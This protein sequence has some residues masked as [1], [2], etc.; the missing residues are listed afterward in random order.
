MDRVILHCDCNG[1][2]ASVECA[3]RPELKSV[4]MIVGGDQQARHGIVLAKNELAKKY[5]I[6]TAETVWQA[7]KKCPHLVIVPPHHDRY[8]YY[9]RMINRVY[10]EYTDL[11]EPFG[12]DESWLDVTGSLRLFGSG[13]QIAD[14]LRRRIRETFGITI[15]VG[16]SF[17]KVFAKLGSDYKKP[18]ATTVIDRENYKS[19]V[20]PLPV[21][22]MLFAGRSSAGALRQMGIFT[23]GDIAGA[24]CSKLEKRLG[25]AGRSL[26]EYANGL[27]ESPVRRVGEKSDPKSIGRGMTYPR[28]LTGRSQIKSAV[29]ALADDVAVRLRKSGKMCKTVHLTVRACDMKTFQKQK[30]VVATDSVS[31][32]ADTAMEIA[33]Q[34]IPSGMPVRA[35]T[36]T[37]SNFTDPD[38]ALAQTS[39]FMTEEEASAVAR[40]DRDSRLGKAMDDI[41]EKYGRSAVSRG[42]PDKEIFGEGD[43]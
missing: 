8:I 43:D 5:G 15:S 12:I 30:S 10:A 33:G 11:V 29:S 40:R 34:I 35:L 18:D 39:L 20:W 14:E 41:R 7:K 6:Q 24:D 28:D 37:V 17:N 25:K 21:S 26:Y 42:A 9:S 32:I 31:V 2:F 3:S 23:I 4:P 16:V 22:D 13:K 19:I 27:D 38:E 36:V 1:F